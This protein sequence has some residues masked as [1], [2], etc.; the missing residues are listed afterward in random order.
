MDVLGVD[1]SLAMTGMA[2]AT[3]AGVVVRRMPTPADGKSLAGARRRV[4]WIVRNVLEFAP[5]KCLTVIE[6][7]ALTGRGG[8]AGQFVERCGLYWLLVDQLMARGPVVAVAPP[9]RAKYAAGSGRASKGDVLAAMRERFPGL[10]VPD[11]NVADALSLMA[12]GARHLGAP[13]DGALSKQHLEAMAT[14]AWPELERK[15]E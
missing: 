3:A 14:P 4:R 10:A 6:S 7:P 11:H 1:P 15:S 5:A 8:M 12:M 9:T 13:V 2:K